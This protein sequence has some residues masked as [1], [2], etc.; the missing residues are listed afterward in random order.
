MPD[1]SVEKSPLNPLKWKRFFFLLLLLLLALG[2]TFFYLKDEKA[3]NQT[4]NLIQK[5]KSAQSSEPFVASNE[6]PIFPLIS[7]PSDETPVN[8]SQ[9][10]SD[11][12]ELEPDTTEPQENETAFL[13]Q[14]DSKTDIEQQ[15]PTFSDNLNSETVIQEMPQPMA[16]FS[17]QTQSFDNHQALLMALRDDFVLARSCSHSFQAAMIELQP[18]EAKKIAQFFSGFCQNTLLPLNELENL[19]KKSKTNALKLLYRELDSSWKGYAKSIFF[20]LVQIRD[21]NPV[22]ERTENVLDR[23]QLALERRQ[24]EESLRLL[25]QL[26][27]LSQREMMPYVQ[28]AEQYIAAKNTLDEMIKTGV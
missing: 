2:A 18:E 19:F 15:N 14:T 9:P 24:I 28:R 12:K 5:M 22:E 6:E 10:V 13:S 23:A 20:S 25:Q 8:E 17:E 4:F 3:Q 26:P 11:L 7:L 21:L 27:P 16:S 1:K